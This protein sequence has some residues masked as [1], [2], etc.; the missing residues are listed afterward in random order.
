VCVARII[1][2]FSANDSLPSV[3]ATSALTVLTDAS[4]SDFCPVIGFSF[5]IFAAVCVEAEKPPNVMDVTLVDERGLIPPSRETL[6]KRKPS[7]VF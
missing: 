1:A 2:P 5:E 4:S 6:E 7:F 3:I